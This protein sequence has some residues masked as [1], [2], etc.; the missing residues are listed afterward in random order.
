MSGKSQTIGDFAV[1]Q[2]SQ[3]LPTRLDIPDHLGWSGT[4]RENRKRFYF[5]RRAPNFCGD[6]RFSRHIGKI[7]DDHEQQNPRSSEIF[8]TYKK[9]AIETLPIFPIIRRDMIS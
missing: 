8:P 3:I 6:L 4:N 9:Q 5:S 7:W 2:P 1:S